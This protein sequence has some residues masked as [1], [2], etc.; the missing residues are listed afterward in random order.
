[1]MNAQSPILLVFDIGSLIAGEPK[2][3]QQYKRVGRCYVPKVVLDAMQFIADRSAE[4]QQEKVAKEFLRFWPKSGW[5]LTS[6]RGSHPKLQPAEGAAM[7]QQARVNLAIA[8]C[9]YG[10]AQERREALVVFVCNTLPLLKRMEGLNQGNLCGITSAMLLQW[11]RA[12]QQP[13]AVKQALQGMKT[14]TKTAGNTG[15]LKGRSPARKPPQKPAPRPSP[16][17]RSPPVVEEPEDDSAYPRDPRRGFRVKRDRPNILLRLGSGIVSLV[18]FAAI[19]GA[20]GFMWK[21]AF[22]ES[23]NPFWQNQVQPILR[24][25]PQ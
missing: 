20:I 12:N 7:S 9:A 18:M 16:A 11:C 19:V 8:R 3:W 10:M 14:P 23:F 24:K 22:P 13:Q 21:M 1:M 2:I 25:L 15:G 17:R 6:V 5:E 4:P